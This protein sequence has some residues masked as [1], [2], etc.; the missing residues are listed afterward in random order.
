[1][2]FN[3]RRR[4]IT[5]FAMVVSLIAAVAVHAQ[6]KPNT[7]PPQARSVL[8]A[9][10]KTAK[11]ENKNIM[12]H[13]EA[14][15]CSWCKRLDEAMRSPELGKLFGDNFVLVALTVLES[16]QKK[17]LENPGAEILMKEMGGEKAG[18][19][20]YA[21]LKADGTPIANSVA[22]PK[23]VNIGYPATAEEIEAFGKLLEKSVIRMTSTQRDQV[24][25]Y[26]KK[27]APKQD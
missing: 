1:M 7:P 13:F 14:S 20:F 16:D 15:W 4:R 8:D 21:F 9:A 2:N 18:L 3:A 17:A 6:T 12:V 11:S 19:P 26:L 5:S 25:E 24:I 10:S 23:S 22:L 27:H